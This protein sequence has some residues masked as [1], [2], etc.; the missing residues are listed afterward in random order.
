MPA[1]LIAP[2]S[3]EEESRLHQ[4]FKAVLRAVL[5]A[6]LLALSHLN[7]FPPPLLQ[8]FQILIVFRAII[9]VLSSGSFGIS[10]IEGNEEDRMWVVM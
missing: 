8:G 3:S 10:I 5:P 4:V 2:W 7:S 1:V 6:P 9:S